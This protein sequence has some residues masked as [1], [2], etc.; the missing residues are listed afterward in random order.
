MGRSSNPATGECLLGP[1]LGQHLSA[2]PA[3]TGPEGDVLIAALPPQTHSTAQETH[4]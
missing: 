1:C 3:E 4:P 2:V